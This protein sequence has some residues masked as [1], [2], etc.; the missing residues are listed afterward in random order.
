M[1]TIAP[2]NV[3]YAILSHKTRGFVVFCGINANN[4]SDYRFGWRSAGGSSADNPAVF[5]Q[6]YEHA[7]M[8]V[9]VHVYIHKK[10]I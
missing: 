5:F 7:C 9:Y 10:G 3:D 2:L 6:E 1:G 8:Y 4:C